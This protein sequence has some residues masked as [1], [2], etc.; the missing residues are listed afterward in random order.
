MSELSS[1][2]CTACVEGTPPLK[3][4]ELTEIYNKLN[5][6]WKVIEEHHLEKEYTFDNFKDAIAFVNRLGDY[7]ESV[8][9]HP[10]LF[11]A[12]GKVIIT[13]WTHKS[14]GLTQSDFI[15]AAHADDLLEK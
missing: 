4:T 8:G 3:G 11:L 7:A 1:M 15:F 6:G 9:H 13:L 14:D 12:W 2:Q 5:A 10:D